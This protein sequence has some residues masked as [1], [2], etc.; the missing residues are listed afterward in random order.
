MI[1]H[2][3]HSN[4]MDQDDVTN[5][6]SILVIYYF[7]LKNRKENDTTIQWN[8]SAFMASAKNLKL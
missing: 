1:E 3:G 8:E 7:F 2:V 5:A 4:R 6:S